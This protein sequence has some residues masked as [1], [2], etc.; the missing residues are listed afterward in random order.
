MICFPLSRI[1]GYPR[2]LRNS[3]SHEGLLIKKLLHIEADSL[4]CQYN[5]SIYMLLDY[6]FSAINLS[7]IIYSLRE[8]CLMEDINNGDGT[9]TRE[10]L[11]TIRR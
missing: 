7:Y 3:V 1:F 11:H 6:N 10:H 8:T 2:A 9:N 4:L 5:I